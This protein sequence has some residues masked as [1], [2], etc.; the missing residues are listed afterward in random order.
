MAKRGRPKIPPVIPET[1]IAEYVAGKLTSTEIGQLCGLT[2][3]A[4]RYRLRKAG[5]DTSHKSRKALPPRSR[6]Q[7]DFQPEVL[8]RYAAGELDHHAVA[9]LY[10]VSSGFA[11]R[12]LRRAG[13]DTTRG[14]RKRLAFLRRPENMQMEETAIQLYQEGHTLAEVGRRI[15]RNTNSVIYIL[16]RRGVKRR[17]RGSNHREIEPK[18]GGTPMRD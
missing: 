18:T 6:N 7:I 9:R 8:G 12:E 10:D 16:Q 4:V 14:T 15:D 1:L 11:L 3:E 5:V 13:M 17:P 2:R